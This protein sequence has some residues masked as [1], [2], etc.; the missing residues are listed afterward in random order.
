MPHC[1][2][3]SSTTGTGPS[4]QHLFSSVCSAETL[5]CRPYCNAFMVTTPLPARPPALRSL[6]QRVHGD[7]PPPHHPHPTDPLIGPWCITFTVTPTTTIRSL[8][9]RVHPPPPPLW[10]NTFTSTPTRVPPIVHL[11]AIACECLAVLSIVLR[12]LCV[13]RCTRNGDVLLQRLQPLVL[14]FCME[15]NCPR[16]LRWLRLLP[17]SRIAPTLASDGLPDGATRG[18]TAKSC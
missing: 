18:A 4:F 2:G 11:S 12:R 1:K 7:P 6:S 10:C 17:R 13:V 3:C 9:Q 14:Q 16:S 5:S 15:P 8:V